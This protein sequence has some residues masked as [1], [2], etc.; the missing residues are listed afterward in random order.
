SLPALRKRK[1]EDKEYQALP[2]PPRLGHQRSSSEETLVEVTPA[3]PPL[4]EICT[5]PVVVAISNYAILSLLD[6]ALTAL[7]PLYYATPIAD[8]GLGLS[9]PTIGLVLAGLGLVNG[10]LQ[11]LLSA[12][13]QRY[14]GVK[15]VYVAGLTCFF[16]TWALFPIMNSIAK[17]SGYSHKVVILMILQLF[18]NIGSNTSFGCI[19]L[20]ITAAAEKG[21]LGAT[22]GVSQTMISFVRM[23]GPA[24]ATSLWALTMERNLMGETARA[25]GFKGIIAGTRKTTPGFR[26]VEKYGMLVGGIDAHRHDLSSMV[27]LK[28]NHVWS[29]GTVLSDRDP[30]SKANVSANLAG[31]IKQAI[32]TVRQVSGFTLLIDVEVRSEA[33]ADEAIEAGADI[34]MLDNL[35]GQ[36]AETPVGVHV[37]SVR[38]EVL[39][40][41]NPGS[42]MTSPP[43]EELYAVARSLRQKWEGKRKFLIETSGGIDQNNLK[44]RAVNGKFWMIDIIP[45]LAFEFIRRSHFGSTTGSLVTSFC[46]CAIITSDIDILSTSAVHQ[47]VQHIDFSLKIQL[48]KGDAATASSGV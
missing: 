42:I 23:V 29:T 36:S 10:S 14:F 7:Q 30:R 13:V 22:N 9:T 34:V 15:N 17:T 25:N 11:G 38:K 19:M 44:E 12:K 35:E 18:L 1:F 40:R 48:P 45:S 5:R 21:C 4:S 31:S 26:L 47:S 46:N 32:E 33:E 43:G 16:G 8:G 3:P 28:D 6:I 27:M 2:S 24:A 20:F 39:I 37:L 41:L